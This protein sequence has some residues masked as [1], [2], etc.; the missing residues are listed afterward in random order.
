M[1]K[2][3]TLAAALVLLLSSCTHMMTGKPGDPRPTR[4][5]VNDGRLVVNQE[6]IYVSTRDA[7]IVWYVPLFSSYRFPREGAVT[8]REGSEE[9]SCRVAEDARSVSCVDRYTRKGAFKYTIR[10]AQENGQAL[11]PLDPYV[12]NN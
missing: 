10:L 5:S 2:T 11:E 9:F 4:L 7:T 8:F 1:N 12:V 3:L 6:P